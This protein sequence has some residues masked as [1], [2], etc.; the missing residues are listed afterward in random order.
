MKIEPKDVEFVAHCLCIAG[1]TFHE[2]ALVFKDSEDEV[3]KELAE[4][5]KEQADR[6]QSLYYQLEIH[7]EVD[8]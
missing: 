2:R 5:Y 6:C 3:E 4:A 1:W 8:A 7:E